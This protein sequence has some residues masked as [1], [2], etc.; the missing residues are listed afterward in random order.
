MQTSTLARE[1]SQKS[2]FAFPCGLGVTFFHSHE[3]WEC[4]NKVCDTS[5]AGMRFCSFVQHLPS[6]KPKNQQNRILDPW[7]GRLFVEDRH[8]ERQANRRP[9][10]A[11]TNGTRFQNSSKLS[12]SLQKC[13]YFQRNINDSDLGVLMRG[14]KNVTH[15]IG[16]VHFAKEFH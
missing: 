1:V 13:Y 8:N 6:E 10:R 11:D 5:P 9:A 7:V 15:F 16:I 2:V 4:K 14:G 3:A 12:S